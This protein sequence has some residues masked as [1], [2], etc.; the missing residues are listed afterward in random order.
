M[1]IL[2]DIPQVAY[3]TMALEYVIKDKDGIRTRIPCDSVVSSA[4]YIPTPLAK[5][6]GR[7]HLVGDCFKV[8]NLRSVI[9]RAYEAAMQI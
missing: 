8:G 3:R 9:W 5:N 7:V 6:G 2:I 4:G 1:S